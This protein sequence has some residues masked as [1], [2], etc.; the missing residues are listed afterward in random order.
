M[1]YWRLTFCVG[2]LYD[3]REIETLFETLEDRGAIYQQRSG[4]NYQLDIPEELDYSPFYLTLADCESICYVNG[5]S[6]VLGQE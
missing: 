3:E 2:A 5:P 6:L 4:P 1:N